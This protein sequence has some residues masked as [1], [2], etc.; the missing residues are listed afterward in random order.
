MMQG[1]SLLA[2]CEKLCNTKVY[3]GIR[4]AGEL[5]FFFIGKK[6]Q[7]RQGAWKR[8]GNIDKKHFA[9]RFP[10]MRGKLAHFNTKPS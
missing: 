9:G 8:K 6:A 7:A 2:F 1:I 5:S 4:R 3:A 10:D